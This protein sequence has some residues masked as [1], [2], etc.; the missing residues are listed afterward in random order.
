MKSHGL[1]FKNG[2]SDF[3]RIILNGICES[4]FLILR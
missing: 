3:E 1:A 2:L 4:M